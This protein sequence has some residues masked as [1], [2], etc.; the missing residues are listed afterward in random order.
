[1]LLR[2]LPLVLLLFLHVLIVT[3]ASKKISP[4]WDEINYPAAGL[5]QLKTGKLN[6]DTNNPFLSKI[7]AALP[8][9]FLD[10]NLP[11]HHLSWKNNDSYNF[12]FQF[13]YRNNVSA[14][15]LV[16][17]SRL[18]ALI[19]SILLL[20][21]IFFWVKS[22]GGALSAYLVL[23]GM[24][25]T[26]VLV[27]RASLAHFEMPMYFF[28]ALSLWLNTEW[29][30]TKKIGYFI[31][32]SVACALA[33]LCKLTALPLLATIVLTHLLF[34]SNKKWDV[35][36]IWFVV[37]FVGIVI[38]LL[39]L[40][41]LPWKGGFDA[42][43]LMITLPF[44][45]DSLVPFYWSGATYTDSNSLFT[46]LGFLIKAPLSVLIL[47][48]IGGWIWFRKRAVRLEFV[49]FFSL[50][51]FSLLIVLFKKNAISTIQL[52]VFYLGW[53]PLMMGFS[54]VKLNKNW[55]FGSVVILLLVYGVLEIWRVHP[56]YIAYFNQIVGGSKNGYKWMADSDQDWGQGLPLLSRYL[57]QQGNPH[58]ILG[59]SG[60]GDPGYYG[61]EYQDFISPALVSQDRTNQL[62]SS[63]EKDLYL[64]VGSKVY[65]YAPGE[66]ENLIRDVPIKSIV[67]NCFLVFDI[68]SN[69]AA[70][71]WLS[72]IY[73][74]I[75]R[76]EEAAWAS[77]WPIN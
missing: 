55:K 33:L 2:K 6:L 52:S 65:Q 17:W 76:P 70:F 73:G 45:F 69:Q 18:P 35:R 20:L 19:F 22:M 49:H 62:I 10:V 40:S 14:D 57:K 43:K 48:T 15:R 26:P 27:S 42:F 68:T 61:I 71:Q 41:Y 1:M 24:M 58:V 64:V 50:A 46:L 59:Y 54:Y 32:M 47:G 21:L 39:L 31:G 8:L 16:F 72:H 53:I 56:N 36:K 4:T 7:M 66:F 74:Q 34:L 75:G 28:T 11:T 12:G 9:L 63:S 67:G 37:M 77:N 5:A 13:T 51:I 29:F 3:D 23:I 25:L 44:R 30:R 60:S 38:G